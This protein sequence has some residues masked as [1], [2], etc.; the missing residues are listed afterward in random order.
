MSCTVENMSSMYI[1]LKYKAIY[2][3]NRT[4]FKLHSKSLNKLIEKE[5]NWLNI[6]TPKIIKIQDSWLLVEF[7]PQIKNAW[8][9]Y[10]QTWNRTWKNIKAK[11]QKLK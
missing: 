6:L 1:K 3:L 5:Y 10:A 9:A 4:Y 7:F 8:Y 11:R 2:I